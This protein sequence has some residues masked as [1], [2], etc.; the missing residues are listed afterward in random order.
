MD[1]IR[2]QVKIPFQV[3]YGAARH[4]GVA[5]KEQQDSYSYGSEP[6]QA[7]Y[8]VQTHFIA[9]ADGVT[10]TQGGAKASEIAVKTFGRSVSSEYSLPL[11][12][13]LITA[14]ESANRAIMDDAETNPSA[15]GM[16]TTLVVAAVEGENLHVAH[17]GDSR[18]YLLRDSRIHQLTIDH[19]RVQEAYDQG[20]MDRQTMQSHPNR[21]VITRFL[22]RQGRLD[23]DSQIVEPG[24]DLWDLS[25]RR[26]VN[27]VRVMPGD[28]ILTCSDGLIERISSQELEEIL[29]RYRRRPD[30]AANKLVELAVKRQETDNITAVVMALSPSLP[31]AVMADLLS[32][33]VAFLSG[34]LVLFIIVLIA[35]FLRPQIQLLL[36]RNPENSPPVTVQAIAQTDTIPLSVTE[37][38]STSVSDILTPEP[39]PQATMLASTPETST[40]H[41]ID[42]DEVNTV[43]I[44]PGIES[45]TPVL[46]DFTA[47][48]VTT[49]SHTLESVPSTPI[50]STHTPSPTVT[51]TPT[52][53]PIPTTTAT[54]LPTAT[55]VPTT[56]PIPTATLVAIPIFSPTSTFT[57]RPVQTMTI[58]PIPTTTSAVVVS[59]QLIQPSPNANL[60]GRQTFMWSLTEQ[61]SE[62]QET[63]LVFWESGENALA[64]GKSPS[65]KGPSNSATVDFNRLQLNLDPSRQLY[66]GVLLWENGARKLLISDERPFRFERDSLPPEPTPTPITCVGA[67]GCD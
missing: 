10:S 45:R 32:Q 42:D 44:E 28:V 61:L 1:Q 20:R 27:S 56:T 26:M 7:S 33:P 25:N 58:T 47:T 21:H 54:L 53:E 40:S 50:A 30:I 5:N 35:L 66:W 48:L 18:A 51:S 11:Q 38:T 60:S 52:N 22:G 6:T 64:N 13:R 9:V 15:T 16:S 59:A 34:A 17:M 19:S 23:V 29:N 12:Q 49:P 37:Q 2:H 43:T 3:K 46:D 31:L 24:S 65:G 39:L 41:I 55:L 4:P 62:G 57:P 8:I 63:E 36:Y 14:F 67:T